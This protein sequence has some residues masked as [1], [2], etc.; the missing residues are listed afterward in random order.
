[1]ITKADSSPGLLDTAKLV[2]AALV[3]IGGI[4]AYYYYEDESLLLR[5][6]GVLVALGIGAVIAFQSAQGQL[7][8]RFIQGSRVEIRKVVWPTRQETIQ[9]TLTVLVFVLIMG[10]FF[11]MLDLFL[12][13]GTRLVTGQGG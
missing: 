5:V 3:L 6:A 4:F 7:L 13:W 10:V 1:M 9:M 2:L 11:W 8:W 12:L